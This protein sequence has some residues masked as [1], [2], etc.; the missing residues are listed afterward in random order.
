[1]ELNSSNCRCMDDLSCSP[2]CREAVGTAAAGTEVPIWGIRRH[3]CCLWYN[4]Y[5]TEYHLQFSLAKLSKGWLR[6]KKSKHYM[7]VWQLSL[8]SRKTFHH[9]EESSCFTHFLREKVY[10]TFRVGFTLDNV[11]QDGGLVGFGAWY[12]KSSL[13]ATVT[14][15]YRTRLRYESW[16][17]VEEIFIEGQR[18]LDNTEVSSRNKFQSAGCLQ[19]WQIICCLVKSS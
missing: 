15:L 7:I 5:Q 17:L 19:L 3:Q 6:E 1:M 8:V 11:S 9:G 13:R 18:H 2:S 10:S 14:E 16:G 4:I 12:V